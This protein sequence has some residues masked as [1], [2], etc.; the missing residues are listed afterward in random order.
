[1]CHSLGLVDH[2]STNLGQNWL[3]IQV[4]IWRNLGLRHMFCARHTVNVKV[5]NSKS[6]QKMPTIGCQVYLVYFVKFP[7]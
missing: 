4:Y 5:A 6:D 7:I 3:T 2:P 1:M